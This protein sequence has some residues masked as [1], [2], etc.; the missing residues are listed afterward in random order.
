MHLQCHN[1]L[2]L[3]CT[4][5]ALHR[6]LQGGM[7]YSNAIT[8]VS[9]TYANEVLNGGQAGWLRSIFMRP[10]VK[11]KVGVFIGGEAA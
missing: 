5:N 7:V 8:T 9:P 4:H 3:Q 6:L 1:A 11:S 2:W 10:E